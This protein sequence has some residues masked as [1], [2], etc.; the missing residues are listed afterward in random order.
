MTDRFRLIESDAYAEL[1]GAFAALAQRQLPPAD[2]DLAILRE[3]V[4]DLVDAM[5]TNGALAE[6]VVLA[7]KLMAQDS[8]V[9]WVFGGRLLDY[10]V[11]WCLGRY[12]ERS[13]E[14]GL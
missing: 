12:F 5:K 11:V 2:R 6:S 4:E 14:L 9:L 8:G 10:L 3:R 7:V 13:L 1:R